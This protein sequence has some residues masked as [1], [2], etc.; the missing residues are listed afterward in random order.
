MLYHAR[1]GL[2]SGGYV[3]V[4][5]FFVISGFLI[6]GIISSEIKAG[7]FSLLRFYERRVRRIFP[8]FF[9]MLIIVTAAAIILLA[10]S[11]LASYGKRS[12]ATLVF[13]SNFKFLR[14]ADYFTSDAEVN[15]LLHMWSL[16]V[17]EQFYI[18]F[19]LLLLVLFKLRWRPLLTIGLLFAASLALSCWSVGRY[20]TETFYLLPTRAWELMIGSLIALGALPRCTTRWVNELL[21]GAGIGLIAWAIFGFT[22]ETTFPGYTAIV[23]CLGAALVIY[24]GAEGTTL[25]SS[26]ISCRPVVYVGLISYSL[27]LFHWPF[28]VFATYMFPS[29][30]AI[31]VPVLAAIGLAFALAMF[32]LRYIEAPFRIRSL[33]STRR[34]VF[35]AGF[36]AMAICGVV[37]ALIV[38]TKGLPGRHGLDA[39]FYSSIATAKAQALEQ[40]QMGHCFL[41]KKKQSRL[42]ASRCSAAN[43][44][45]LLIGDS[46]AAHLSPGLRARW[47][48]VE[49]SYLAAEGCRPLHGQ[50][51]RNDDLCRLVNAY[52]FE[53]LLR[54]K[55][56]P[57]VILAAEWKRSD[58][59]VLTATIEYLQQRADQII[60]VG[61]SL[62]YHGLFPELHAVYG[63][64][65]VLRHKQEADRF[66]LD[67]E[68]RRAAAK[69]GVTYISMIDILCPLGACVY[70]APGGEY[71]HWD[72][73]HLTLAGSTWVIQQWPNA[74]P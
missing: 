29:A 10:P 38:V 12:I 39:S 25:V 63:E 54:A 9:T 35:V 14:E 36:T 69:L 66:S 46:H 60:L 23:P 43:D 56:W 17:E 6:T 42:D 62:D 21:A 47:P 74:L 55:R 53:T 41:S 61:P 19:P 22:S 2:C 24:S 59:P 58:L 72:S 51:T 48:E 73:S 65:D 34:S 16:S 50:I 49:L 11:E 40:Y 45:V 7:T 5:I 3:G 15:P 26:V 8:A 27:Y 64:G 30:G 13:L 70:K 33:L 71:M 31:S 57:K 67:G 52:W 1:L 68:M 28:I 44:R 4:D 37:S 18:F 20:P 32:S